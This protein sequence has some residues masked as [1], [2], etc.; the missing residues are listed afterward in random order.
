M[1]GRDDMPEAR[2]TPEP[3]A[4]AD[5]FAVSRESFASLRAAFAGAAPSLGWRCPFALP[6]W[7]EAWWSCFGSGEP[8]LLAVR[9]GGALVGV[10]ALMLAGDTARPIGDPEVCDHFDIAAAPGAAVGILEALR[11]DLLP[12]GVAALDLIRVRPDSIAA[13]ELV[14]A[15]RGR[16]LAFDF[17]P[18][19][20]SMELDLPASW[21]A[22]LLML[23]AKPRHELRRKLRRLADTATH[24]L[25][26]AL[27]PAETAAALETFFDLFHRNGKDKARFMTPSMERFFTALALGLDADGRLRLFS[28]EIEGET[29]AVAFCFEHA[30]RMLL[31]N[32][33]YDERFRALSPGLL[34]KAL[35]L[36]ESIERGVRVFDFLRGSE[37]YKRHL[38]GQPLPLY[39]C[40]ITLA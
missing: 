33:A 23:A 16:G 35:S 39:S 5:A 25:R 38:G 17:A 30:G 20:I 34:S 32:N 2:G 8:H 13:E 24:R 12:R 10:A 3:P 19:E 26:L 4:G 29:A 9:R 7:I 37:G 11:R 22:Y 6:C 36:R 15:A 31:Y 21:E 14:P 40:R 28:L 18:Q 27:T 1:S